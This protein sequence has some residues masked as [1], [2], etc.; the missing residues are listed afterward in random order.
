MSR[1][2]TKGKFVWYDLMTTDLE[3]AQKFYTSLIGWGTQEFPGSDKPYTMWTAG[4]KPIGGSMLLPE[5][6]KEA[7]VPPHW[8]GFV[9]TPDVDETVDQAEEQ[10]AIVRVPGTDIPTVGRFAILT[11][12]HGA[13][14]AVFSPAGDDGS[15]SGGAPGAGEISWHELATDDLEGAWDFYQGLFGWSVVDEMDMGDAGVYRMYGVS[16]SPMGGIFQRPPEMPMSAWLYYIKVG[17][18]DA[19]V[20]RVKEL[21]GQI[22]NGPMEVPGGDRIAQCMD[23]QGGAFALHASKA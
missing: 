1:V 10:G 8:V 16:D 9:T 21:G 6:A 5:E 2:I 17:D 13:I 15:G 20:T 18:L 14:F 22:M 7:G 19:A 12:P 4:D 23:P 3:A 11:D